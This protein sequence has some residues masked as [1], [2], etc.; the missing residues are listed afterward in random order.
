MAISNEL[1]SGLSNTSRINTPQFNSLNR[2]FAGGYPIGASNPNS[3]IEARMANNLMSKYIFPPDIPKYNFSVIEYEPFR[4]AGNIDFD[5]SAVT[6]EQ[7]TESIKNLS[8]GVVNSISTPADILPNIR[9][10]SNAIHTLDPKKIY[11]LPLPTPIIDS[12]T[13]GYDQNYGYL[14]GAASVFNS[15]ATAA[16]GL[17]VNSMKTVTLNTPQYR[18]FDFTWKL[19]PKSFREAQTIQRIILS[20]RKA[21][22]PKRGVG[23]FILHFPRIFGLYFHPNIKYLYKFKPC[24]LE[25]ISVDYMGGNPFPSFYK[26][27][28]TFDGT[29]GASELLSVHS[30]P[31]SVVINTRWLELEYWLDSLDGS[32]QQSDY[33]FDE[34]GLYTD[35]P[36]DAWSLYKEK[37]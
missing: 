37:A 31:E 2:N 6:L 18:R 32:N 4:P 30:P 13:V 21:M 35:E 34:N 9:R 12:Y 11:K 29:D 16:T 27:E 10:L 36:F 17:L 7:F 5:P 26:A 25:S 19:A 24:V 14:D 1:S 22:T 23:R 8:S 33:K 15:G 28:N 20:L 3:I